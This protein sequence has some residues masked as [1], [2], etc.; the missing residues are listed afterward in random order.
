MEGVAK[1]R[2]GD[3]SEN[4]GGIREMGVPPGRCC[5]FTKPRMSVEFEKQAFRLGGVAFSAALRPP[6]E[7]FIVFVQEF[8]CCHTEISA[9]FSPISFPARTCC[10]NARIFEFLK[11]LYAFCV[12]LYTRVCI[13]D[14]FSHG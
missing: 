9:K 7:N 11:I 12:Q 4:F 5:I 2:L 10:K 8:V 14:F 3:E 6:T 13:L 1:T